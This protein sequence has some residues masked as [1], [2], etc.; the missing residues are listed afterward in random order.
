[1]L[2]LLVAYRLLIYLAG[3]IAVGSPLVL[4]QVFGVTLSPAARTTVVVVSLAAMIATYLAERRV[5][6]D[7][8]DDRTGEATESYPLRMRAAVAAAV[9]GL[10]VGV[11][12][13]LEMNPFYGLLFVGGAYLFAYIAYRGGDGAATGGG[14]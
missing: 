6:L 1:M 11:Y 3:L 5:G 7:H 4:A 13:A 10:A 12:V 2:R 8:V 14:D 9:V